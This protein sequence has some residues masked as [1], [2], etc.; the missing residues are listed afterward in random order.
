MA[1]VWRHRISRQGSWK[2]SS[3]LSSPPLEGLDNNLAPS[4]LT[5]R[6]GLLIIKRG[7]G[8]CN[9]AC[10]GSSWAAYITRKQKP[11]ASFPHLIEQ[12]S[13][14]FHKHRC[15]T[16]SSSR[17]LPYSS[18]SLWSWLRKDQ[19]CRPID[20]PASA[21]TSGVAELR[22]NKHLWF[23]AVSAPISSRGQRRWHLSPYPKL[24]RQ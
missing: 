14:L 15:S 11:E 17:L 23:F 3:S 18:K 8:R 9:Q 20:H 10:S 4:A 1:V 7:A 13:Q 6:A 2:G 16:R 21:L 19:P 5:S 22:Q 12:S 24:N